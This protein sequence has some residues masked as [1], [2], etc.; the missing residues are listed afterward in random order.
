MPHPRVRPPLARVAAAALGGC[1][2]GPDYARPSTAVAPAYK[3]QSGKAPAWNPAQP[4][5]LAPRGDWWALFNDP[6]LNG[7]EAR[8]AISNQNVVAAEAAHRQA[9]ALVG[10][11]APRLCPL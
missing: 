1:A 6:T 4:A 11:P 8:V 5:D 9:E 7:L 2:V 10:E 3:E